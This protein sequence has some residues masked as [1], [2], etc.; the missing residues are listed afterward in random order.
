MKR[1]TFWGLLVFGVLFGAALWISE[2]SA[3]NLLEGLPR[4]GEYLNDTLPR[5]RSIDD[6]ARWMWGLRRWLPMLGDTL[7]IAFLGTALA[8]A[9]GFGLSFMAARNL[10]PAWLSFTARRLLEAMRTVP[11]LVFAL[12]F[13]FAFG[14]GPLAGVLALAVHGTGSLGKLCAEAHEAASPSFLDA[15]RAT[16]ANWLETIRFG[17]A[18]QTLSQFLSYALLR[19]EI[20]V[21]SASVIGFIGAGGIGQELY[22]AIRQFVYQDVSAICLLIIAAVVAI[23]LACERLRAEVLGA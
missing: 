22:V 19:F 17:V 16:G 2:V 13:V 9:G 10:A 14:L 5:L 12:L 8:A 4:I 21:R 3:A 1:E 11:E 7:L 15:V 18:P 23:D 20:N 6:G